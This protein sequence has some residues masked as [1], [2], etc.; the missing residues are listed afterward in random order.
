MVIPTCYAEHMAQKLGPKGQ[1]VI[2]KTIREELGI[3]PGD[4]VVVTLTQG[5][6]LVQ[7][8]YGLN[9]LRGALRGSGMLELLEQ[10]HRA[11]LD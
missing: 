7:S 1:V 11:E 9:S 2:P 4:D 8:A 10:D 3:G 6:A 5:G